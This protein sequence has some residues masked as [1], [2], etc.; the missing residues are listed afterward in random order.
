MYYHTS[1]TNWVI[2]L[3]SFVSCDMWHVTICNFTI[4]PSQSE[5]A[6]NITLE[7]HFD[8][9]SKQN[10]LIF[11]IRK[12]MFSFH[13]ISW[14]CFSQKKS[15]KYCSYFFSHIFFSIIF[16]WKIVLPQFFLI[17]DF[18]FHALKIYEA[19]SWELHSM[20]YSIY[21]G[22]TFCQRRAHRYRDSRHT[23]DRGW[24]SCRSCWC[25]CRLEWWRQK[26]TLVQHPYCPK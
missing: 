11:K 13:S 10:L 24:C 20:I 6:H 3:V 16:F 7:P 18:F 2:W 5:V 21:R 19:E 1:V 17:L 25:L 26:K 12:R 4:S 8:K 22:R 14:T 15:Q 23:V 9:K